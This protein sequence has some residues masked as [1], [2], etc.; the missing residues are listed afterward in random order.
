MMLCLYAGAEQWQ[1]RPPLGAV[2]AV[3]LQQLSICRGCR[4]PLV[5]F[6]FSL[7]VATYP[8]PDAAESHAAGAALLHVLPRR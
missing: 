3:A 8:L 6:P 4:R 7:S 2:A 1:Q 5:H